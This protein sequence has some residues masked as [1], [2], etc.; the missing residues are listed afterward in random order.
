MDKNA[1][2]KKLE[3][4]KEKL[5]KLCSV[6]ADMV[7][8]SAHQIRTSLSALKWII[9]MFLDSD[10]G[11]LTTEQESLLA[12]AYE[13]NERAISV[14]GELLLANKTE[15]ELGKKY[16]FVKADMIELVDNS[17]F[18]FSGEAYSKGIEIIFLKPKTK[19]SQALIDKEKIRVVLQ[20][21][22]ENAIKYSNMHGKIFIALK[23]QTKE[24]KNF[25][26]FSIKDTGVGITEAGKKK[27]FEKFYRDPEAEKKEAVG[28]G[29]GLYNAK[30][31][32][33]EHKGNIWFESGK[34]IGTTF[35]FNLPLT[36]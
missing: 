10:L 4:E 3:E 19:L 15:N 6:K 29:I 1:E 2:L 28:S 32:I 23:E 13:S 36:K 22:L 16:D 7:S 25:V 12:K 9:K 35:S 27:I 14:V 33:E 21:L 24:K 17:I 11:K 30:K 34:D 26:E 5:E 18:D 20:N 8:M 31:I